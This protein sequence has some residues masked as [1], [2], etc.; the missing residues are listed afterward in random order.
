[1]LVFLLNQ[2]NVLQLVMK[3]AGKLFSEGTTGQ[4]FLPLK[5]KLRIA[6]LHKQEIRHLPINT[7]CKLFTEI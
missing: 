4:K 1:M 3:F 5:G 7:I 2:K 6:N